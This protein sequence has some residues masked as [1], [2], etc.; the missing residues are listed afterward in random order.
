MTDVRT[1]GR[2]AWRDFNT[3]GMESSGKRTPYK[4]DIRAFVDA[5]AAQKAQAFANVAEI[6][7]YDGGA[8]SGLLF[9]RETFN[10]GGAGHFSIK[11]GDTTD[12]DGVLVIVDANG[13]RWWRQ[14]EGYRQAR[15]WAKG[16][17]IADD[18][19][20]LRAAIASFEN[21]RI[22]LD[23]GPFAYKVSGE[24]EVSSGS[25]H[26]RGAG[27]GVTDIITTSTT[28]NVFKFSGTT[29]DSAVTGMRITFDGVG[30]PSAGAAV[31]L[32][33]GVGDILVEE[34]RIEGTYHGIE[35]LNTADEYVSGVLIGND[36]AI[37]HTISDGLLINGI[38]QALLKTVRVYNNIGEGGI[39]LHVLAGGAFHL[40]NCAFTGPQ[41]G[42]YVAPAS[43]V[44]VY[45]FFA[46]ATETDSCKQYGWVFDGSQGM[47]ST[48]NITGGRS[49]YNEKSGVLLTGANL[50]D[51]TFSA[52]T[53]QKNGENGFFIAGGV[54]I[55][56]VGCK[57]NGS[58]SFVS[59]SYGYKIIGGQDVTIK[60]G[61]NSLFK[62]EPA[63]QEYGLV[64]DAAF[65]NTLLVDGLN[66]RASWTA[67]PL[68]NG[69]GSANITIANCPGYKNVN[70]GDGSIAAATSVNV[71]H[72]L[73]ETPT[74][75]GIS[76]TA[77][78]DTGSGIR[79]WVSAVDAT[80]FTLTTSASATFD[81]A[82][83]AK[84]P[85]AP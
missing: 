59:A 31:Y 13:N 40:T 50:R 24:I 26:L 15:W 61:A 37:A 23:F 27:R 14:Y 76:I 1:L 22:A 81:F 36:V 6:Q 28:A 70:R 12:H 20:A 67:G 33:D 45:D 3:E 44:T 32:T 56:L 11:A 38:S 77:N 29:F 58:G 84:G 25:A 5:V 71:A 66:L 85:T 57:A 4:P 9:G 30:T 83:E 65:T 52:F 64:I 49:G 80:N 34:I 7:A 2:A 8:K 48:V 68:F 21:G 63:T 82:W 55:E 72:G 39:G 75:D 46:V 10:D 17:G 35:T 42:V 62:T 60:G 78:S 47:I 53:A 41:H 74:I 43:G 69:S 54:G 19:L 16:D 51:V 18:T 79:Y 73:D